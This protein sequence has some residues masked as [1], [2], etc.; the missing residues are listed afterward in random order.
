MVDRGEAEA[1]SLAKS[2]PGSLLVVDDLRA[3]RIA[4]QLALRHT[5]TLGILGMAKRSGLIAEVAPEVERLRRA[6]FRLT[7]AL[8]TEFLRRLGESPA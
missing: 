5:G 2:R 1:L 6:G 3:R 8:V 4:V 7:T